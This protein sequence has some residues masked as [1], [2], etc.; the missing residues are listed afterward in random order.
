MRRLITGTTV[1]RIRW[2]QSTTWTLEELWQCPPSHM[3]LTHVP[4]TW[5]QIF[6]TRGFD[7][8]SRRCCAD[9]WN[10]LHI[11]QYPKDSL[12]LMP[13]TF[14]F[15]KQYC[16]LLF[17]GLSP[18][19]LYHYLPAH[20]QLWQALPVMPNSA[21]FTC[22][23]PSCDFG[24]EKKIQ[25][26]SLEDSPHPRHPT[27]KILHWVEH[28]QRPTCWHPT[29]PL[30]LPP[31]TPHGRYTK[32]QHNKTDD[33]HPPG[34]LWPIER[35]LLHH[36]ISLQNEGFNWDNSKCGH[37]CEDFFPPIKIPVIAH[38]PWV[39]WNIL[40][41]LGIYDKVEKLFTRRWMTVY[42]STQTH[43]TRTGSA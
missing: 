36:F 29:L 7:Q 23:Y 17:Q 15:S 30:I 40:I 11:P 32:E 41:L 6:V 33:L 18:Q 4:L 1:V 28:H 26:C 21:L 22:W 10:Q 35:D 5:A 42:T 12:I 16:P 13:S 27:F 31:S 34:F 14:A 20:R 8:R 19:P 39:Q 3:V 2:S 9:H 43:T 38:T 37:F 25:T 24:C